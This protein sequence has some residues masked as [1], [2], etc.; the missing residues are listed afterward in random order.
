MDAD[1]GNVLVAQFFL[2]AMVISATEVC[3]DVS[4]EA[5]DFRGSSD[6]A[7]G[8]GLAGVLEVLLRTWNEQDGLEAA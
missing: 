7:G 8:G 5:A 2:E 1:S 6:R 4:E 3:A